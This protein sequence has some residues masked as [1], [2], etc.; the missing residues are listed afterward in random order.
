MQLRDQ[1]AENPAIGS[2]LTLEFPHIHEK[3]LLR[4][5]AQGHWTKPL[6]R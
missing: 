3:R 1:S 2:S 6:A 5:S 4:I